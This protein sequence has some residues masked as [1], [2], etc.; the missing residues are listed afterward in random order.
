MNNKINDKLII[1]LFVLN[2]LIEP[3]DRKDFVIP[4]KK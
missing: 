1:Y 3:W 2:V 4:N